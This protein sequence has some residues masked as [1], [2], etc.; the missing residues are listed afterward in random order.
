[1][2]INTI[3]NVQLPLFVYGEPTENIAEVLPVVWNATEC[4]TSPEAVTRQHGIDAIL[5]LGAQKVSSLV[6][7]MIAT[8]LGDRDIYIRRRVIYILADLITWVPGD[9]QLVNSIRMTVT[10]YL[11][12]MSEET[13]FGLMEVAM[14]DPE[15][16]QPIY[17]ILNACPFAGRYLG[18]IL[19]E[20]KNPLL[21]RQKAIYFVGIVGY[22]EML[23][24]LERVLD[25]LE[26]RQ[27][28]Q[29]SMSFAPSLNRSDED[30]MPYLRIAINQMS[31]H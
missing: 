24:V 31:G 15:A 5:E 8:C 16:E 20:W 6:A 3:P 12:S 2:N 1:M 7:F 11:H 14:M 19:T 4:L 25:R 18:N 23:P 26:A 10:N 30:I 27:S 22:M 17:H 13:T 29:Y 21:I 28:R 9:E